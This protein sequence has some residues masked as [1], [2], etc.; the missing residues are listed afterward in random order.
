ML[1]ELLQIVMDTASNETLADDN[2]RIEL[3]YF[4]H[5]TVNGYKEVLK[6]YFNV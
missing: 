6:K 5:Q 3:H 4:P 2:K 1:D